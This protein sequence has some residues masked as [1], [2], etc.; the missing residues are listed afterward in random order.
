MSGK[1]SLR[2]YQI[3]VSAV[4]KRGECMVAL[5]LACCLFNKMFDKL[6]SSN[7]LSIS[8]SCSV[9]LFL[10]R[11]SGVKD[12]HRSSVFQVTLIKRW[13]K[14]KIQHFSM[15]IHLR[16]HMLRNHELSNHC[17]RKYKLAT[18]LSKA[19]YE[20]HLITTNILLETW[21]GWNI[22]WDISTSLF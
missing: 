15:I 2:K 16:Q 8:Q 12:M 14:S 18:C 21:T 6:G 17:T 9:I 7:T 4:S 20:I 19:E 13:K 5:Q 3:L 22:K 1:K 11:L 10:P